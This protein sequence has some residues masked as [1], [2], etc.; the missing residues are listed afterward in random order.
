MFDE[1]TGRNPDEVCDEGDQFVYFD[2][3][4]ECLNDLEQN[5]SIG[6]QNR[7]ALLLQK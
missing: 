5:F 1:G 4:Y 3:V 2:F 7:S 6:G